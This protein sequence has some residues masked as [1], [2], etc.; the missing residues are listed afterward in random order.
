M[1]GIQQI[2][3]EQQK[4]FRTGRTKDLAFRLQ[5]LAR[6]RDAIV[7]NEAP[8]LK[9]LNADLSKSTYEGYLS[10]VGVAL[11]EIRLARRKLKSWSRPRRVRTS[12]VGH[13]E[14]D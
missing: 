8:I 9:A 2:L 5:N 13:V 12:N 6:L 11:D 10:E 14:G 7:Q 3:A 1:I 4:F